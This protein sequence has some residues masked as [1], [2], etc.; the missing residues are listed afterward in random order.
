ML[1]RNSGCDA[2]TTAVLSPAAK[3]PLSLPRHSLGI[4]DLFR[5]MENVS[6]E[7]SLRRIEL[8]LSFKPEGRERDLQQPTAVLPTPGGPDEKRDFSRLSIFRGIVD[9]QRKLQR[10]RLRVCGVVLLWEHFQ[11]CTRDGSMLAEHD[12]LDHCGLQ[13]GSG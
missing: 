7:Q 9:F 12:F 6:Q 3:L 1:S 2:L 13:I 10:C 11:L 4:G 8:G 5:G